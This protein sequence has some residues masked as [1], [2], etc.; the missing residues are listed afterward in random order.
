MKYLSLS[1]LMAGSELNIFSRIVTFISYWIIQ[2]PTGP[3]GT[4]R[5]HRGP[6]GSIRDHTGPYGTIQDHTGQCGPKG[7]I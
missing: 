6:Y 7:T 2:D 5:D 1:F 3:Y 4:I